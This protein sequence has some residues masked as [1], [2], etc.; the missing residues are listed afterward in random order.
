MV[1][2]LFFLL[3]FPPIL[4]SIDSRVNLFT[5]GSGLLH[6]F[7]TNRVVPLTEISFQKGRPHEGNR[8]CGYEVLPSSRTSFP[9]LRGG[10]VSG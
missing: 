9:R 1:S 10:E 5:S 3:I 4:L 6:I 8:D 7:V 2:P